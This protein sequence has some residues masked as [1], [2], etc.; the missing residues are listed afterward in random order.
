MMTTMRMFF[1]VCCKA[2]RNDY[3]ILVAPHEKD[4]DADDDAYADNAGGDDVDGTDDDGGADCD[5][6]DDG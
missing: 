3:Q 5:D 2:S 4:G 6:D 1:L